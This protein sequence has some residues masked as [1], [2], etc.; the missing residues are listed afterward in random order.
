MEISLPNY[1]E[2]NKWDI[3]YII[4]LT[5]SLIPKDELEL[6]DLLNKEL[7]K[8]PANYLAGFGYYKI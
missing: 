3:Y 6:L 8:N 7:N 2:H 1:T 5:C 4:S